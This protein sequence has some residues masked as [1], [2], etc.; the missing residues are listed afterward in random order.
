M[1]QVRVRWPVE[2]S[3][4][5]A[6]YQE[7]CAL[8]RGLRREAGLTQVELAERLDGPRRSSAS[9]KLARAAST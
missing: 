3:T 4:Y 2:K 9:T 1:W 5:S 6:Q 7:L 8:L